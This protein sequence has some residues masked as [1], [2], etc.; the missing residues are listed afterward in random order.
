MHSI[1]RLTFA[2]FKQKTEKKAL[3]EKKAQDKKLLDKWNIDI[4][5][6]PENE[7]DVK[8]ASLFKFNTVCK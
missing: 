7:K 8:L 2:Y 3:N 5:L 1:R 6:V 4:K